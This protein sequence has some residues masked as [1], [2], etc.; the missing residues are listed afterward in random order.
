MKKQK[1]FG[2]IKPYHLLLIIG[3]VSFITIYIAGLNREKALLNTFITDA[4]PELDTCIP[5]SRSPLT[6]KIKKQSNNNYQYKVFSKGMGWG[7]P[8]V[9]MQEIDSNNKIID[10][11]V[12][13][14][15][16]TP[17]Y[18]L[19][20]KKNHF[21]NQFIS[22]SAS[23]EFTLNKQIDAV[24]GATVSSIG[25]TNAVRESAHQTSLHIFGIPSVKTSKEIPLTIKEF[26]I[27]IIF[28]LSFF[29]YHF[30]LM[31]LRRIILFSSLITVGFI[32]NFPF[33]ISHFSAIL[34]GYF[35]NIFDNPTWWLIVGLTLF[36][37]L[38]TGKNLYCSWICPFGAIQELISSISG[39]SLSIHPTIQ[40]H[41]TKVLYFFTLLSILTMVYFRSTS[42]GN[43]EPFA[44][45]FSL[46]AYGFLWFILP[47]VLFS[48]FFWK[49]F[50][51]RFFCPAG[52]ALTITNRLRNMISKEVTCKTK[53]HNKCQKITRKAQ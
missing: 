29:G 48:S 18:M 6:Y 27:V 49:R 23:S 28:L 36:A 26:I 50:Y 21:F 45:L 32:Y 14:H 4:Y 5:I 44:A 42:R 15:S 31:K 11:R 22:L 41:G 10:C 33:S 43:Y 47:I 1:H 12:L 51:C 19:K 39:F 7:G 3:L 46:D 25:F 34:L 16:E 2:L 52:A 35:P 20:L 24:S 30:K 13:D 37:I 9:L 17:S 53:K 38:I 8:F 40:K